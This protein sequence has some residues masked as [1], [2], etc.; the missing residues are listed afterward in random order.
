MPGR[1]EPRRP[2]QPISRPQG[3]R[4]RH[5]HNH[6]TT[7][8]STAFLDNAKWREEADVS[9]S[10]APACP[11][12]PP[13]P[14]CPPLCPPPV[15]PLPPLLS[16]PP[17]LARLPYRHSCIHIKQTLCTRR[18]LATDIFVFALDAAGLVYAGSVDLCG[19]LGICRAHPELKV[20]MPAHTQY[21]G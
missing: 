6:A 12:P 7:T 1:Q 16:P 17:A 15:C 8:T 20:N 3:H 4:H 18:A 10:L 21:Q 13:A 19:E 9:T 11:S 2:A 5:S 14:R